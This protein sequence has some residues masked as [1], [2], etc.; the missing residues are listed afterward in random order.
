MLYCILIDSFSQVSEEMFN[1][2][3]LCVRK[4][5]KQLIIR[6]NDSSGIGNP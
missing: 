5:Q 3:M 6:N 1:T 2:Y 4:M